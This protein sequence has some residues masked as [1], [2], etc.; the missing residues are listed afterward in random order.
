MAV[1]V[2]ALMKYLNYGYVYYGIN[3]EDFF[4]AEGELNFMKS[5]LIQYTVTSEWYMG[6]DGLYLENGDEEIY[7]EQWKKKVATGNTKLSEDSE[8]EPQFLSDEIIIHTA[9]SYDEDTDMCWIDSYCVELTLS[10]NLES[11][12]D[13]WDDI[14]SVLIATEI[15]L[16]E[17]ASPE[18][19]YYYVEAGNS[20]LCLRIIDGLLPCQ[21]DYQSVCTLR[22]FNPESQ[23]YYDL[24]LLEIDGQQKVDYIQVTSIIEDSLSQV[25]LKKASQLEDEKKLNAINEL[26][27][28]KGISEFIAWE[29]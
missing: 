16:L 11:I 8:F 17:D 10:C 1:T 6:D 7:L 15:E 25:H 5:G 4:I 2:E 12:E 3:D 23:E 14:N 20:L 26:L 9:T 21:H 19:N 24:S 28:Q 18:I 22:D 29:I 13:V 27:K